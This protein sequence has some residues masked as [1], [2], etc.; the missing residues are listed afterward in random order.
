MYEIHAQQ[1]AAHIM[2]H[3][4]FSGFCCPIENKKVLQ[5]EWLHYIHCYC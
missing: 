4:Y 2:T 5:S 3:A 1:A